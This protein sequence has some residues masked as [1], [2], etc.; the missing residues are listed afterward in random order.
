MP[1]PS[2]FQRELAKDERR[3]EK[4]R[5][6]KQAERE[7]DAVW[8]KTAYDVY[9]RDHGCS[10]ASG[11][12]LKFRSGPV[13]TIADPHHIAW[14]SAGGDDSTKNLVTLSRDEHDMVHMRGNYKFRL[15]VEGDANQTLTFRK[16][17][18]ETGR[19]VREWDSP[20]PSA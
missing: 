17:S 8:A 10:R 14:R 19:L 18:M 20:N 6:K 9:V 4:A 15:E 5:T 16:Y 7:A 11:R 3:K 12:P 1:K 13:A 2:R